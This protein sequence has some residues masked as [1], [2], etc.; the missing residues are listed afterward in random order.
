MKGGA[1]PREDRHGARQFPAGYPHRMDER[2]PV[3]IFTDAEGLLMHQRADCKMR[4]QQTIAFLAD[5]HAWPAQ[6]TA[7]D[8]LSE[9]GKPSTVARV[10]SR[11]CGYQKLGTHCPY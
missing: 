1:V 9:P 5:R 2:E 4:Q 8:R 11:P 3:R 6:D 10:R 7:S